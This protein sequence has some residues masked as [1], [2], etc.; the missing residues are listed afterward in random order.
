MKLF[1]WT[2]TRLVLMTGV[3]LFLFSFT[4]KRN[5]HRKLKKS[6]VF[7]VGENT[8]FIKQETVN[9]LLIEYNENASSIEKIN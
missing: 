4:S 7:F 5:G 3:V 1:N 8:L 2:N 6:E 9:K